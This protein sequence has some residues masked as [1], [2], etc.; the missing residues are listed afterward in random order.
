MIPMAFRARAE[1]LVNAHSN[2]LRVVRLVAAAE[3]KV[4]EEAAPD[5]TVPPEGHA[6]VVARH[7]GVLLQRLK[8]SG[9]GLLARCHLFGRENQLGSIDQNT[10]VHE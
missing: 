1:S 6:G 8:R 7:P 3:V 10:G 2:R 9:E 5:A 4:A